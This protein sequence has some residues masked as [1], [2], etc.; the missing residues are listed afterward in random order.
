MLW[1]SELKPLISWIDDLNLLRLSV[2]LL[3]DSAV[4]LIE[5][6]CPHYFI[7]NCNLVSDI[8]ILSLETI[9]TRL[10]PINN[11][12]LS[13]WFVDNYIRKCSQLCPDKIS[14]LL[15]DVSST[16]NLQNAVLAIIDWRLN[17]TLYDARNAF[18]STQYHITAVSLSVP[19]VNCWL[20]ELM[21]ISNSLPVYFIAVALLHVAFKIAQN[22]FNNDLLDS[23]S[24]IV[25]QSFCPRR[26][27]S[28]R[29]SELSLSKA[30]SL[31]KAVDDSPKSRNTL[32]LIAI[33]LSK[34]YLYRTLNY[35]DSDSD[36]I[37]PDKCLFGSFVLHY[38]ILPDSDRSLYTSDEITGS[39][40]VQLMCCA[41]RNIAE[42]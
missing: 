12:W 1:A 38:R 23:L 30:V 34:A 11:L 31:M 20:S 26:Y 39:L 10:M 35:E 25:G 42:N 37:L 14:R 41:R 2:E 7:N 17:T 29:S 16:V 21:K 22:N 3:H 15:D 5:A 27:S 28:R 40:K 18:A 4:W 8:N 13:W 19:I 36:S 24:I 33:E 9:A 32:H 6:R